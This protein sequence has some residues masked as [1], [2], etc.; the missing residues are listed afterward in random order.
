MSL[1]AKK[2]SIKEQA[3]KKSGAVVSKSIGNYEKHPFFIKKVATAQ[4]LLLEV[5]L[6]K[7][8]TKKKAHA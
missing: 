6:P 4:A 1:K 8:L 5:G 2:A 3:S 7:E